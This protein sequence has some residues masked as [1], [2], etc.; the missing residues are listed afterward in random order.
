MWYDNNLAAKRNMFKTFFYFRIGYATYLV[1]FIGIINFLTTSYF[2]AIKKI[3]EIIDIF[4]TFE[5]YI[6]TMVSIGLPLVTLV[7][8]LHFKRTG[9][10][11]AESVISQQATPYNFMYQPGYNKEV[12]GPAYLAILKINKK[13]LTGEKLSESD[14]ENIKHLEKKLQH[15]IDGG[16]VGDPPRGTMK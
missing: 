4:P 1:F 16:Y 12:F 11:S 6:I 8:W 13:R 15:L 10:Y 3:P 2:L 7:G 5:I 14:C 9:A